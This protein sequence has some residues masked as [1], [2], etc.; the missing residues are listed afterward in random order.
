MDILICQPADIFVCWANIII[1]T[2][3]FLQEHTI[4]IDLHNRHLIDMQHLVTTAL[5]PS[6][7]KCIQLYYTS[8]SSNIFIHILPDYLDITTPLACRQSQKHGVCH[9]ISIMGAPIHAHACQL[10]PDKLALTKIKFCTVV[11]SDQSQ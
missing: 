11:A 9:H 3:H 10:P 5:H 6:E 8:T 2:R 1:N 4:L 7:H